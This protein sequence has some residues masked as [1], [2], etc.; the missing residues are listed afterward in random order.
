MTATT[1]DTSEARERRFWDQKAKHYDRSM[2]LLGRPL[3]RVL[4]LVADAVAGAD[5]VL[6]VGA[7]TGLVTEAI[8]PR[9][10]KLVATD[11]AENM[12][13]RLRD[14]VAAVGLTNVECAQA[15]LYAL[16]YPPAAF[17]AV[18]A[19]NIL[20][21]VPDLPS[22]LTALQRV[23]RPGGKLIAP[24]FC[25]DETRRAWFVSRLLSAVGQPMHRRFSAA[26]LRAALEASGLRITGS[27]TVP[28]PIPIVFVGA[29]TAG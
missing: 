4:E 27:E 25:H 21:L 28:G 6:E 13:A 10:R 5:E 9:V 1:R 24:T 16:E 14:R 15:D 17:D 20:H 2:K 3:P 23:L 7:G 11:Y 18:V 19:S 26:S 8:A 29:V 12:V 22:A